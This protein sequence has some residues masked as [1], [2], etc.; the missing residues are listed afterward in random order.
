MKRIQ[1]CL[2]VALCAAAGW[3]GGVFAQGQEKKL[4]KER[5]VITADEFQIVDE[6]GRPRI[7]LNIKDG[8]PLIS[9]V[10]TDGLPGIAIFGPNNGD[11]CAIGI[12]G[13]KGERGITIGIEHFGCP[14]LRINDSTGDSPI[15][16]GTNPDGSPGIGIK[17]KG[18]QLKLE[19]AQGNPK[20]EA[21]KGND[22]VWKA[23]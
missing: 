18:S 22:S 20:L 17:H 12:V 9:L 19:I 23:P 4:E 11:S 14:V 2:V 21:T 1:V 10:D 7:I 13:D 8:S 3:A 15:V 5:K 6:K 16:L